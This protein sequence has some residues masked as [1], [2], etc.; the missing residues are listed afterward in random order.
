MKFKNQKISII[1]SSVSVL[2][3][4]IGFLDNIPKYSY[5]CFTSC[6]CVLQNE[7]VSIVRFFKYD[8]WF[9]SVWVAGRW[10]GKWS[11]GQWSVNLIKLRK[12]R[13]VIS[14]MH[15]GWGLFYSN[16]NFFY[17]GNKEETNLISRS[18]HLNL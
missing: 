9:S 7:Y 12:K 18:S 4:P 11:V 5:I 15:F 16:F 14:L 10:V 3:K 2:W 1:D 17:S 13:V 6:A 8:Y